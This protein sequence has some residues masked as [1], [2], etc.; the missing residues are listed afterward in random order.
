M[1][2]TSKELFRLVGKRQWLRAD[3]SGA[4]LCAALDRLQT[5]HHA[6]FGLGNRKKGGIYHI[7]CIFSQWGVQHAN[8]GMDTLGS[9]ML[10]FP[11]YFLA[12]WLC[13]HSLR[14]KV[15]ITV[16]ISVSNPQPGPLFARYGAVNV[17]RGAQQ[18]GCV[19]T[20]TPLHT[21][22]VAVWS[23]C[24]C[25]F[26]KGVEGGNSI[27]TRT[28]CL[29]FWLCIHPHDVEQTETVQ[30]FWANT[31]IYCYEESHKVFFS[32]VSGK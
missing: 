26:Q 12:H 13:R 20:F 6:F 7:I 8:K 31:A 17:T 16:H 27:N 18:R 11:F 30:F 29:F 24:Q 22:P 2:A 15:E 25:Q 28:K 14:H 10:A 23:G 21:W 1:S 5:F 4:T 32:S 3:G 9:A 19:Y